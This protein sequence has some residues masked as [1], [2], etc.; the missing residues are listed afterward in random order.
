MTSL[1]PVVQT[2][3]RDACKDSDLTTAQFKSVLKTAQGAV[4]HAKRVLSPEELRQAW[5]H[6]SWESVSQTLASSE[7]FKSS[8]A[9]HN[10]CKQLVKSLE[11]TPEAA[12]PSKRKADALA[13]T[14]DADV[15]KKKKISKKNKV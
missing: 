11:L 3:I 14:Q 8:T 5:D 9:L 4:R 6:S 7:K 2:A 12:K 13:E 15:P 1:S 10:A